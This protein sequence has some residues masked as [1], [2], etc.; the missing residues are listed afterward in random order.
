MLDWWGPV[1]HEYYASTE[2]IGVCV[3][4]PQEWLEH[5]GSVGRAIVGKAHAVDDET[6]EELPHGV[7]GTIY[8]SN[9]PAVS[10]H[11]DPAKS[12]SIRND[13]GWYSVGDVGH[14]DADGYVYLTDRK[15]FMIIS[16]GVNIYP[17][18]TEN[19]LMGHPL[20]ADVAVFGVPNAEYG[21]EVK[22]V[23]QLRDHDR[24]SEVLARELID[25]CRERISHI[26]CPRSID[27]MA[28]LPRLENGKLYKQ[29]LRESYRGQG[30]KRF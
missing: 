17:Q 8:F 21:E 24:A 9:G 14:I 7:A 25:Y 20:V 6:G 27:F 19:T 11:K 1:V 10:Y 15:A 18:E 4:T 26:K 28:Q 23:V 29:K 13:K 30:P 3:I 16:G 2:A 22:A 12:D 5:P